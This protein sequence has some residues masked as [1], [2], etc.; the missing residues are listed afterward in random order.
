MGLCNLTNKHADGKSDFCIWDRCIRSWFSTVGRNHPI[1]ETIDHNRALL[2][3][4]NIFGFTGLPLQSSSNIRGL[5]I[6]LVSVICNHPPTLSVGN[7]DMGIETH[8]LTIVHMDHMT[9]TTE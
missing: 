6:T 9:Q 4:V 5:C 1:N 3:M 7:M 2:G 8:F